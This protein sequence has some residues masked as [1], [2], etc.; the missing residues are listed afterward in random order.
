M[1]EEEIET[2]KQ[3]RK[4][5]LKGESKFFVAIYPKSS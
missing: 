1:S 3:F 2:A 5:A 4:K